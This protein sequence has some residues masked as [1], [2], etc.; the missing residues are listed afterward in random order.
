MAALYKKILL[1]L[2]GSEFAAEALPHAEEMARTS[3][4][5]L[6]LFQAV[7]D[8]PDYVVAQMESV[9]VTTVT[10]DE[11]KQNQALDTAQSYL[12]DLVA[13]LR[14]RQID[15]VADIGSGDPATAIVEYVQR[16]A[17]DLIVM[18]THGRTGLARWAYGSVAHKVLQAAPCAVLVVRPKGFA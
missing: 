14:H 6:V 18:S 13:S 9:G 17:V 11:S 3:G 1:P 5:K 12:D 4:A 2:D 10:H 7:V 15:T 16:E 8:I